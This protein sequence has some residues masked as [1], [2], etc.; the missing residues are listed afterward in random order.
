MIPESFPR[1]MAYLQHMRYTWDVPGLQGSP[2]FLGISD[3]SEAEW[4]G[5]DV[6]AFFAGRL[7]DPVAR[8]FWDERFGEAAPASLPA[9]L[10]LEAGHSSSV[11]RSAHLAAPELMLN[12]TL[13]LR[14][15][16]GHGHRDRLSV[17]VARQSEP[18]DNQDENRCRGEAKGGVRRLVVQGAAE[19][20]SEVVRAA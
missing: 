11:A 15:V 1:V 14:E 7:R 6:L 13:G 19:V 12:N 2:H 4:I 18:G 9:L 17:I 3:G 8:Y 10:H 16:T 20:M 5:P